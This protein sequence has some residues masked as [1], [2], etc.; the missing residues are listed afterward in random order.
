MPTILISD[1]SLFFLNIYKNFLRHASVT[2]LEART[3]E[4]ATTLC[5]RE[6]PDLIYMSYELPDQSGAECCKVLKENPA[7]SSI[8]VI[9]I[10]AQDTPLQLE[11]S[12]RSGCEA[13][14]IK[15]LERARFVDVGRSLITGLREIRRPCLV[16][17]HCVNRENSFIAR[18]LDISNGGIFLESNEELDLN[19][20]L[21][22]QIQLSRPGE[23]GSWIECAGEVA[24]RN[25]KGEILKPSHPL[26]FGVRFSGLKPGENERLN[27]YLQQLDINKSKP[28]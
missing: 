1:D 6:R 27:A 20:T 18:G 21:L 24:W 5:Q 7:L 26:G 13:I 12:R 19:E 10:C 15:P 17:A 8:P 2:I 4:A 23:N 28:S 14:L 3:A 25:R 16:T 9:L 11:L 22:L